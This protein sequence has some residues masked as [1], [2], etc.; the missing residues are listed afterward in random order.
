[1]RAVLVTLVALL[2]GAAPAAAEWTEPRGVP[3]S[4]GADA[5]A[6]VAI[7]RDGTV[8]VG[9][10]RD[11]VRVAIRRPNGRWQETHPASIGAR[12]V[13][14]VDVEWVSPGRLVVSWTR[15]A[16]SFGLPHGPGAI[17]IA[18][19][20][21]GT[22]WGVPRRIGSS[23]YYTLAEPRLASNWRGHAALAWRCRRGTQDRICLATRRPSSHFKRRGTPPGAKRE[24][25]APD[26]DV[27]VAPNGDVHVVWTRS[28]GPVIRHAW[29][30][31]R[32]R[33]RRART[34]SAA[35]ASNPQVAIATDGA[36]AVSWRGAPPDTETTGLEYGPPFVALRQPSAGAFDAPR[37][38]SDVP[39]HDPEIAAG[40]NGGVMVAYSVDDLRWTIRRIGSRF[41]AGETA[42][43]A[44]GAP[45]FAPTGRLGLLADATALLAFESVD[46]VQVTERPPAG[47]FGAPV[48]IAGGGEFPR[49]AARGSRAVL[50]LAV[51]DR[52]ELSV[53]E[54]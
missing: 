49:I 37:Q 27:A 19:R 25:K 15:S 17:F 53:R 18:T 5:P 33:W 4:P 35:P 7:D 34:I 29:L 31:R 16:N 26:H 32:E 22:G 41:D 9:F 46:G 3:D 6:D 39:L 13:R 20:T 47:V 14:D 10:V 23:P 54:P 28:R 45:G 48:T 1:M 44:A 24:D 30:T 12:A 50:L 51:N 36:V 52:L 38:L 42:P 8:A 21:E 43:I 2:A 40:V 11:G